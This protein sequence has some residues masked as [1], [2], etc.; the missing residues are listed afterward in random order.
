VLHR[1][2]PIKVINSK[3]IPLLIACYTEEVKNIHDPTTTKTQKPIRIRPTGK[4]N[5]FFS[6]PFFISL[7]SNLATFLS[8][9]RLDVVYN[10]I[11]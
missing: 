8:A 1:S 2:P 9:T 6:D 7:L 3:K 11:K 10:T 4:L 5:P